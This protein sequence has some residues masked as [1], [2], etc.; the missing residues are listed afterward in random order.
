MLNQYPGENYD[1]QIV[2]L[3]YLKKYANYKLL[4]VS[5]SD[6]PTINLD[7]EKIDYDEI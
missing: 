5:V 4:N 1:Q 6:Y 2:N 3:E 7:P